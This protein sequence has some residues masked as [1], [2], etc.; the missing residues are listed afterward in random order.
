MPQLTASRPTAAFRFQA[1]SSPGGDAVERRVRQGTGCDHVESLAPPLIDLLLHLLDI[2]GKGDN[3]H[4]FLSV[5]N[6]PVHYPVYRQA[7]R[8][9]DGAFL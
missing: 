3:P 1:E 4:C 6:L 9:S 5:L 8:P 7:E 2:W